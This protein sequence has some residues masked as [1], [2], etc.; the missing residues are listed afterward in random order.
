MDLYVAEAL[1]E[2]NLPGIGFI[3]STNSFL[4]GVRILGTVGD[5]VESRGLP[6]RFTGDVLSLL[7]ELYGDLYETFDDV[8]RLVADL[9]AAGGLSV[10]AVLKLV[11]HGLAA[12]DM[13]L[14]VGSELARTTPLDMLLQLYPDK[15][16]LLD[17]VG[18]F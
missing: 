12:K 10:D 14:V 18:R 1:R 13:S 16:S 11:A 7:R 2:D 8:I 3:S 17:A 9:E 15:E 4:Q 6:K 5:Y